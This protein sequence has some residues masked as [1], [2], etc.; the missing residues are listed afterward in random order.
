MICTHVIQVII[1]GG[2]AGLTVAA[3]LA[4]NSITTVAVIEAGDFADIAGN[5]STVPGYGWKVSTPQLDWGFTTTPQASMA[6]RSLI[7]S[8]GKAIGG[9]SVTNLQAYHRGTVQSFD[10]W[11]QVVGDNSFTFKNMLQW[12]KK[13]VKYTPP[14]NVVR[15]ANASIPALSPQAY[16][17]SG[18]PL[19][20]TYSNWANPASSYG[21]AAWKE[22]GV[23]EL[24]DLLSGQLIGNQYSPANIQPATQTRDTSQTSFL[25]YALNSGRNN[26][27]LYKTSLAKRVLFNTSSKNPTATGVT[28]RT[29]EQTYTLHAKKEVIISAGALQ[30]PQILMV[31]GVGPKSTLQ[32]LGIPVIADRPGVGRNMQ[33]H[34]F[35]SLVYQVA[36]VTESS[37]SIPENN[38]KANSDFNEKHQGILTNTGA[39]HFGWEKLPS[40][41]LDK[42]DN[43]TRAY[44]ASFPSDWPDYELVIG[45]LPF[46][47]SGSYSGDYI[48]GIIMLQSPESRGS[49]SISSNNTSD[50]PLIDTKTLTSAKDRAILVQA[51]HRVREFFETK[52]MKSVIIGNE[53]VPG[54]GTETDEQILSYLEQNGGP[55]FHA[56]CTCS[57]GKTSD[58]NAVV[59]TQGRVIG[60]KNLRVVDASVFP[61]LPPGHL[62]STVCKFS[63]SIVDQLVRFPAK[64]SFSPLRRC[65]GE[66]RK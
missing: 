36:T 5:L 16:S 39:D 24:N 2:T 57:M 14:D 40:S 59:D 9:S 31:S 58:P 23:S 12:Y 1:G 28:V 52:S 3:R 50:P 44:L 27:K 21:P 6:D 47:P 66:A 7:Y 56:A 64:S 35:V 18:G 46:T 42:L 22:L 29:N 53:V 30:A 4:E 65:G 10:R 15:A 13:S 11:A 20:V 19:H 26:I 41:Y 8:R 49:I 61:L 45:D 63:Q 32:S 51:F 43:S 55:G 48:Q 38:D 62:V 33:D 17:K 25:K 60:V 54:N 37:L 34:M